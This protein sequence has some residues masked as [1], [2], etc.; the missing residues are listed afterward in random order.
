MCLLTTA[1]IAT[2]RSYENER[3]DSGL[4]DHLSG[5]LNPEPRDVN[6][7]FEFIQITILINTI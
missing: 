6:S 2:C 4:P 7:I 5:A 3:T 1:V